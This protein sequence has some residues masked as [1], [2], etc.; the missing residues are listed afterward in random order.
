V[1]S[2]SIVEFCI[3]G[4]KSTGS[5]AKREKFVDILKAWKLPENACHALLSKSVIYTITE[6]RT[7]RF[8]L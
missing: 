4:Y 5:K 1:D 8:S 2:P 3:E 7:V 6:N